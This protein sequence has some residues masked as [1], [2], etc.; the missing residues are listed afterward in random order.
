[1]SKRPIDSR[2]MQNWLDDR[3]RHYQEL[4]ESEKAE[5]TKNETIT[6]KTDSQTIVMESALL[7]KLLDYVRRNKISEV[8]TLRI[9][10]NSV[11][12]NESKK[13]TFEDLENIVNDTHENEKE[14]LTKLTTLAKGL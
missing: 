2:V 10:T 13:L 1:M 6:E 14:F 11:A 5:T 7:Y 9:V 8:Q 12:L 3:D 4:A